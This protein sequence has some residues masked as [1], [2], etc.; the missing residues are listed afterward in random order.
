M[1]GITSLT[2]VPGTGLKGLRLP[3]TRL[4]DVHEAEKGAE[5]QGQGR[6][7]DPIAKETSAIA[8]HRVRILI[9]ARA[10]LLIF[11]PMIRTPGSKRSR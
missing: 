6:A 2:R 7:Q 4:G 10:S 3:W 9:R 8:I 1:T 11:A 5:S